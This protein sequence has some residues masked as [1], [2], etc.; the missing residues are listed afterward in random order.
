LGSLNFAGKALS[1]P[2]ALVEKADA[3]CELYVDTNHAG[4]FTAAGKHLFHPP[5][6]GEDKTMQETTELTLPLDHGPYA[7]MPAVV[8]L[9]P[10]DT[11]VPPGD[12]HPDFLLTRSPFIVGTVS[13]PGRTLTVRF[14]YDLARGTVDLENAAEWMDV[15]APGKID[16]FAD[17]QVPH[18]TPPVFHVGLLYLAASA[19]DLKT[20]TFALVSVLAGQYT[21]FDRAKGAILPDFTW[22]SFD[23]QSH[24]FSE[25][26]GQ[27]RLIDFWATWC[28]PCV[29]D[30]ASKKA[31]Y[32]K[33]HARGFDMLSIDGD[34]DKPDAAQK[35]IAKDNL[36]WQ[37]ARYDEDL[38]RNRF[39]VNSWPTMILVDRSGR[40]VDSSEDLEG[41][42]LDTIL[43]K[44]L[45][46]S[47]Q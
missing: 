3:T 40:I 6:A 4:H 29:A 39:A 38:V 9:L 22:T 2:G 34:A 18:G 11:K 32:E 47:G 23:G 36:P 42:T 12:E 19:V 21:R 31:I 10:S 45:P 16:Y 41:D 43:A 26:R 44:L 15:G 28:G 5:L 20:R 25:L 13:V 30:L 14:A 1:F 33:Y 24:K 35:L 8:S 37:Q 17:R 27:Y 7:T 46:P